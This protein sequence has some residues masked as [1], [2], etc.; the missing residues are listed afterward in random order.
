MKLLHSGAPKSITPS[1]LSN[2]LSSGK[3][4]FLVDIRDDASRKEFGSIGGP[5]LHYP[6]YR[7]HSLYWELP[8]NRL[9]VLYDIRE[10][11][12]STACRYLMAKHFDPKRLMILKGGI[13]AWAAA[14][15]PIKKEPADEP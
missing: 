5:T 9:L 2:L 1:D 10:K 15:L 6:L 11:Q 3:K 7:F 8:Q 14:G 12:V 13:A 4:L